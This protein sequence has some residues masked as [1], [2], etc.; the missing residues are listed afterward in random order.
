MMS[1]PLLMLLRH[2]L[3]ANLRLYD[4]CMQ[5]DEEQLSLSG[6][7]AF[8]DVGTTLIHLA[9]NELHYF[10]AAGGQPQL[11]PFR[12]EQRP[13]VRSLRSMLQQ[14]GEKLI[15]LAQSPEARSEV[16][17]E[18][19]GRTFT[20]PVALFVTQAVNH[21]T[22]HRTNITTILAANDIQPPE[23]DGW[24]YYDSLQP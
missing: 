3:W 6:N 13:D 23:I 18:F 8:G 16:Q 7:G 21:A 1:D 9:M 12:S 5:L 10:A 4:F 20:L 24:A 14:S 19:E 22:E 11:S 15:E 2:N 17:V